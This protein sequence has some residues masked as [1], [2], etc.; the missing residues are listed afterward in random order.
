MAD[1]PLWL[2]PMDKMRNCF[3]KGHYSSVEYGKGKNKVSFLI[4]L[5]L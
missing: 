4:F 3:L 1:K 5:E 2:L